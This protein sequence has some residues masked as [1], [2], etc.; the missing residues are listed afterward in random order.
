MKI[1]IVRALL[2]ENLMHIKKNFSKYFLMFSFVLTSLFSIVTISQAKTYYV[3]KNNPGGCSDSWPGTE[4]NPWCTISKAAST[5]VAGDTV[6]VKEGN[7]GGVGVRTS[8]VAYKS[9]PN[10][11]SKPKTG[12]WYFAS[13]ISQVTIDGFDITN[14]G[15]LMEGG[16]S[17]NVVKNCYIHDAHMGWDVTQGSHYNIVENCKFE[18]CYYAF[19]TSGN[20]NRGNI[21]RNNEVYDSTDDGINISPSAHGTQVINN[22]IANSGDDGI[23]MFDDGAGVARGNLIYGSKGVALWMAGGGGLVTENNTVIGQAGTTY[24]ILFW[25]EKGGHKVYNNIFYADAADISLI[26]SEGSGDI[27]YNCWYNPQKP[28]APIGSDDISE[29]PKFVDF[30]N[31]DFH[32]QPDSPC[33]GTGEGGVDMGAYGDSGYEPPPPP[34]PDDNGGGDGGGCFIATAAYGSPMAEEV[35]VLCEFRNKYLLA[36]PLG[37]ASVRFYCQ[38]SPVVAD[39]IR[40]K[41]SLRAMAR[42]YLKPIV[43]LAK[44]IMS[45]EL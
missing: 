26:F 27:N 3:A 18:R 14:N 35:K 12:E 5:M 6:Y 4:A 32:L 42:A 1:V 30:A 19:H 8:G 13:G 20:D 33:V 16:N 17:Y 37:R 38:Y 39:F 22:L 15:P 36:S 21:F 10:N 7:Y 44:R 11:A 45:D 40:T 9:H 23:H 34:P 31:R 25:M 43:W 24:N 2:K 41:K 28:Q 29:N